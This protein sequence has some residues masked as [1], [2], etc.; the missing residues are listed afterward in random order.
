MFTV[1]NNTGKKFT[2]K[3]WDKKEGRT[4]VC[5]SLEY[6]RRPVMDLFVPEDKVQETLN[7]FT[8]SEFTTWL[9]NTR[10]YYNNKNYAP[11]AVTTRS[12]GA[13]FL[14]LA[15]KLAEKERIIRV[16]FDGV[17]A[18]TKSFK[19][20]E[21]LTTVASYRTDRDSSLTIITI[22]GDT[23]YTTT[24]SATANAEFTRTVETTPAAQ[25]TKYSTNARGT[26]KP[27]SPRKATHLVFTDN[28]SKLAAETLF[29]VNNTI[30]VVNNQKE[31]LEKVEEY[32]GYGFTAASF[33]TAIG[34]DEKLTPI[35]TKYLQTIIDN[36][37]VA[38]NVF[39]D[40]FTMVVS[41]KPVPTKRPNRKPANKGKGAKPATE[42]VNR[43]GVKIQ[44]SSTYGRRGDKAGKR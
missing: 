27:F 8:K 10:L 33:F 42:N 7:N 20:G 25:Y 41:K 35:N 1:F 43:Q 31:L 18:L 32:K 21:F 23:V 5:V 9:N 4:N 16:E 17:F 28:A 6:N 15:H 14:F 29:T 30:V 22:N 24:Y 2:T 12:N 19:K 39:E 13:N 3:K 36:F 26:I 37:K 11:I 38:H 34:R 44:A 40:G